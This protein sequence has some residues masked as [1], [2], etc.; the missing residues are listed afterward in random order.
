MQK[1]Y[2]PFLQG[3]GAETWGN[4]KRRWAKALLC[5]LRGMT[6]R[7]IYM[8]VGVRVAR[9]KVS[10]KKKVDDCKSEVLEERTDQDTAGEAGPKEA[11]GHF[12]TLL[13]LSQE[14]QV[15]K[16]LGWRN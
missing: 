7:L 11:Q 9:E 6:F 4:G 13:P 2:R 1:G 8:P 12:G 16:Q 15:H 10:Q 5:L 14:G 3:R